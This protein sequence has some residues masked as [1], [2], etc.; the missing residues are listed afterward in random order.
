M[1]VDEWGK[2]ASVQQAH[3]QKT[4]VLAGWLR[5]TALTMLVAVIGCRA[6]AGDDSKKAGTES[7]PPAPAPSTRPLEPIAHVPVGEFWAGSQPGEPGRDPAWE[8]LSKRIKLGPFRIDARPYPGTENAPPRT[9]VSSAE[10]AALCAQRKGRLCTEL[11]WERA[12]RGSGSNRYPPGER[13]CSEG[14]GCRSGFDVLSMTE[15]A[16]WTASKFGPESEKPGSDV[17]RGAPERVPAS[18]RRC[19]RRRPADKKVEAGFRC[20]YGAPNAANLAEPK[21][22]PPYRETEISASQLKELLGSHPK[23]AS[24]SAG[25]ALFDKQASRTVFERGTRESQGFTLT[26]SAVIW[27][28]ARGLRYLVVAGHAANGSSYVVAFHDTVPRTL[29]GS[30]IMES[31][32]GPIALAYAASI[33]PRIHFSSCWGCP[34]ETGKILFRPL[35]QLVFLQP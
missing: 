12:C 21:L 25:A 15:L 4:R 13:P 9:G 20:C 31:E 24:L 2:L 26:T 1:K 5:V 29:A 33:R 34:G 35:E 16:E 10:A 19:A 14:S 18:E 7:A 17:L 23:T 30:F 8:P 11:E 22:G 27:Q 6:P 3:L 28:P 32:P